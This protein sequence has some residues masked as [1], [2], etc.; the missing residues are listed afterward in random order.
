MANLNSLAMGNRIA[1][2]SRISV[3]S[4]FFNLFKKHFY[5]PTQSPIMVQK[6]EFSPNDGL[7]FEHALNCNDPKERAANIA[8]LDSMS[9][10]NLGNYLLEMCFSADHQ[11]CV[12]QL[13]QFQQLRYEPVSPVCFFEGDEAQQVIES[14]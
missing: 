7:K 11:F 4:S 13:H 10:V 9:E 14:L 3:K 8:A 5:A 2:D 1:N 6:K 12:L